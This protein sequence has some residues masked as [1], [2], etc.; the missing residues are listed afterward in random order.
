MTMIDNGG[1]SGIYVSQG[2]GAEY[3][4]MLT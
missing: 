4:E 1:G 2:E 3:A